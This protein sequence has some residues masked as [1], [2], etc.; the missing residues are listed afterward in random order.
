MR[1]LTLFDE[2]SSVWTCK[3]HFK[4][5]REKKGIMCTRCQCEKHN[6]VQ[7][8]WQYQCVSCIYRTSLKKGTMM[9]HSKVKLRT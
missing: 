1:L 5:L 3:L 7:D 8:Q 9:E 6:W 4:A 2:F